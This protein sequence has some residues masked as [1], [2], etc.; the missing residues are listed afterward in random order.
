MVKRFAASVIENASESNQILAFDGYN[1]A[2]WK[3]FLNLVARECMSSGVKFVSIDQNKECFKSSEEID[4]MTDPLLIWDTGIDPTLLY[5]K[6]HKGG[7]EGLLDEAKA[8]GFK[9]N[10]TATRLWRFTAMAA[11]SRGSGNF[12]M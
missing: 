10:V 12:M 5:G 3:L 8:E 4:G 2:D 6:I 9:E 7:H 1:T 11:L